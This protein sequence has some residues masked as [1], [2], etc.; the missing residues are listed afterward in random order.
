MV[1]PKITVVIPVLNEE[2][3]LPDSLRSLRAQ[4][5]KDYELVVV[6][7]GSADNTAQVA[8]RYGCR[9][10]NEK[11]K[12]VCFARQRGFEEAQGE[13]IVSTDADTVVPPDWLELIVRS[14]EKNPKQVAVYGNILFREREGLGQWLAE[15]FFSTFLRLNHLLGRPHFCGSNF[16]IRREVFHR[17]GGFKNGDRFYTDSEDV[18]L[19]LKLKGKGYIHFDKGLAVYTSS[20]RFRKGG[21]R[22]IWRHTKNYCSVVWLRRKR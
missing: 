18:Q 3:L 7:N 2:N 13:I 6:D 21:L 16:A 9:V 5:F 1:P 12:G 11:R 4:T 20:R 15:A 17:A 22:Y 14:F 10:V 8:H 19:S